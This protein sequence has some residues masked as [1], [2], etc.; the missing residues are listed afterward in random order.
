MKWRNIPGYRIPYRI[1]DT[2]QVQRYDGTAWVDLA[3]RLGDHGKR[4]VVNLRSKDGAVQTIPVTRLMANAFMGG[5]KPGQAVIHRNK[6]IHD[7]ALVN[8]KIVTQKQA[9]DVSRRGA[10]KPVVKYAKDGEIVAV[11]SSAVEAAKKE[12]YCEATICN[13]CNKKVKNPWLTSD[14]NFRWDK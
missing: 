11:Y 14:Y 1:S 8:L 4:V 9:T 6:A 7:N 5:L 12:H 10:R 3:T 2:G 13:R